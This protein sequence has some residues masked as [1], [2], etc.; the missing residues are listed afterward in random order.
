MDV[1]GHYWMEHSSNANQHNLYKL[2]LALLSLQVVITKRKRKGTHTERIKINNDQ[3]DHDGE[4]QST[5]VSASVCFRYP[6][7]NF[8][9]SL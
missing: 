2:P 5:V 1:A 3:S 7:I 9:L 8:E 6:N 4:E